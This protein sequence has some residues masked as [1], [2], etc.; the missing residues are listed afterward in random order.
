[1][2][3]QR[4]RFHTIVHA[5]PQGATYGDAVQIQGVSVRPVQLTPA[6]LSERMPHSFEEVAA[7]LNALPRMFCEPDGSLVWVAPQDEEA[8]Q[9][10]GNLFDR[11]G[12]LA[13][14]DLKGQCTARAWRQLL[15]ALGSDSRDLVF[16]L[17]REAVYLD[18]DD[19]LKVAAAE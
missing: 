5:R 3:V 2:S 7:S 9:V 12:R 19:F 17:V 18:E 10:E 13:F 16:Q 14:V 8:W 15:A 4:Y 1:V 6:M 11:D